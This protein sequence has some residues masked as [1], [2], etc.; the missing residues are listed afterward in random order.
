MIAFLWQLCYNCVMD[1]HELGRLGEKEAVRYLKKNKYKILERDLRIHSGEVDIVALW[2]SYIVFIEVKTRAHFHPD[3][4]PR[5]AV[6]VER[7]RR[8]RAIAH[9]YCKSHRITDLGVRFDIIEVIYFDKK[10]PT[11]NHLIAAF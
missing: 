7:Q 9:E 2:Q 11:V 4:I 6:D 5:A 8:Y 10:T 3:Y 1:I